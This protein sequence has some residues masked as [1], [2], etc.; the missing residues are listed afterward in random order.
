M[1]SIHVATATVVLDVTFLF[2]FPISQPWF[3]FFCPGPLSPHSWPAIIFLAL[4]LT[5]NAF[6]L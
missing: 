3:C 5:P 4:D 6:Y 2:M 1:T